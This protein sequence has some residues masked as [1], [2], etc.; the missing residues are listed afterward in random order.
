MKTIFD[1]KIFVVDDDP[2]ITLYLT[3]IIQNLGYKNIETFGNG[4]DCV[5]N[6]HKN[7]EVVFLDYQMEDFNGLEVLEKIKNYFPGIEVVFTTSSE[8]LSVA[9]QSMNNGAFDFLLKKNI[10]EHE[11]SNILAKIIKI[12]SEKYGLTK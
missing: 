10:N 7:P 5:K 8:D 6:I 3:Q 9:V 1:K 11:V 12:Q 4:M 2:F